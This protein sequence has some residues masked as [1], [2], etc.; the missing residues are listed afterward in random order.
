MQLYRFKTLL[1]TVLAALALIVASPA[2]GQLIVYPKTDFF[3]EFWLY[4]QNHSALYPS[5]VTLNLPTQL[6]VGGANHLGQAAYYQIEV[7]FR[8]LTQSAPDS[9]NHSASSLTPICTFFAF[10]ADN[11]TFE[12]PMEVSFQYEVDMQNSSRLNVQ[13]LTVDG[14]VLPIQPTVLEWSFEK[15]GFY[16]NL[17][18]ELWRYNPD[19]GALN[20]DERYVSLWLRLDI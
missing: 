3:T 14:Q 1:L 7:K 18:F 15:A 16:G 4:S 10:A 9:F 2:L 13:S 8:N 6:Y 5:N 20:Y 11:G 19:T 17:F 12:V